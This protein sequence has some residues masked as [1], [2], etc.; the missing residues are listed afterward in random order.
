[1]QMKSW[2][3]LDFWSSG[4]WQVIQ[5]K[6]DELDQK[7][8]AYCPSRE[9]IFAA[10]DATTFER[11]KVVFVGQDPYP[12]PTHATGCAFDVPTVIRDYPPT[13]ANIL[14]EYQSDLH[15]PTP[16]SGNLRRWTDQGV[17]LW[18]A[19]PTCEARKSLSHDWTE[20]EWLTKEIIEKTIAEVFVFFGALSRKFVEF[21]PEDKEII[22]VS[23]PSP[24]G[25]KSGN[26]PFIGS[27]VF[28]TVNARLCEQGLSPID[29]RLL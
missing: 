8:I 16:S 7:G 23:H 19:I 28:S 15:Y 11:T 21:V 13:L 20:W 9:N 24:R 25:C 29:W 6:L 10:L 1:M 22:C 14:S 17:L 4:E 2:D 26:N 12:A 18:N 27:R 5:E 3:E